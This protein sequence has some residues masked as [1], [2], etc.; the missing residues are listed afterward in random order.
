MKTW[1][2]VAAITFALMI[3]FLLVRHDLRGWTPADYSNP[4]TQVEATFAGAN[5]FRIADCLPGTVDP[6]GDP[7]PEEYSGTATVTVLSCRSK[8]SAIAV[9][10]GY[11]AVALAGLAL[12]RAM[13][14]RGV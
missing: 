4:S 3:A 8:L 11:V 12:W 1:I 7:T 5:S 2:S 13:H 9:V 10:L 14:R 6:Y